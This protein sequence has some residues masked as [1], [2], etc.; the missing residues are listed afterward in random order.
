VLFVVAAGNDSTSDDNAATAS[1]PCAYDLPNIVCVAATNNWDQ[2][3]WFSN[4]GVR[5]VDIAAP[6]EDVYSTVRCGGY[7]FMSGTSMATPEVSGAAALVLAQ[8]PSLTPEQVRARL[9]TTVDPLPQPGDAQRIGS[10]GRLNVARALGVGELSQTTPPASSTNAGDATTS[11]STVAFAAPR[12]DEPQAPSQ[13]CPGAPVR[14][15]TGSGVTQAPTTPSSPSP[16]TSPAPAQPSPAPVATT[17]RTVL[18]AADRTAPTI[19]TTLSGRGAL[20]ALLAGR[21]RVST[22]VSER[23]SLRL[24]LILDA[25][26]AKKLRLAKRAVAVRIASANATATRAGAKTVA[27][28]ITS[29]AKRALARARRVKA[30]LKT[31]AADASGNRRT[32]SNT[33]T[34]SR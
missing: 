10:H 4:Y 3:A 32:R 24:E 1:Y 20:R 33:L 5:S 18:P 2:L 29:K 14:S 15:T 23:S 7:D 6:G 12:A 21:L 22:T 34:L 16:S 31:T 13:A 25:R 30:T 17:P 27:L 9:M 11:T 19:R 28:H 26:T 8:D